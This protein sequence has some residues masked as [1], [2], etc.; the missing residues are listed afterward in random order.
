MF[1]S[2]RVA[3]CAENIYSHLPRLCTTQRCTRERVRVR[4]VAPSNSMVF[5]PLRFQ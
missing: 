1:I 3:E 4:G 2:R 5:T